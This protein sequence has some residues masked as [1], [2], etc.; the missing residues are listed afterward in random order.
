MSDAVNIYLLLWQYISASPLLCAD[1]NCTLISVH[2]RCCY[3]Y[4]L[5]YKQN[6]MKEIKIKLA[7]DVYEKLLKVA[8]KYNFAK[9]ISKLIM[10]HESEF[11][12]ALDTEWKRLIEE[13]L[14]K[15]EQFVYNGK[16]NA[17]KIDPETS[18]I[19]T[20]PVMPDP[21]NKHDNDEPERETEEQWR[22]RKS[23][24]ENL[25]REELKQYLA[26]NNIIIEDTIKGDLMDEV[27]RIFNENNYLEET[28]GIP[29]K[30][31]HVL[32]DRLY[33]IEMERRKITV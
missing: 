21:S 19:E 31:K 9:H 8:G 20:A 33:D 24:E 7:D 32:I 12:V 18:L 5:Y 16:I 25:L 14:A 4:N 22:E 27:D 26:D 1:T 10:A 29:K 2:V 13:R 28:Y 23:K 3:Q 17:V 6:E 11:P 15:L 30:F